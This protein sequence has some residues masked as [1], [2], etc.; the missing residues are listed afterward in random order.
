VKGPK[1]VQVAEGDRS[2]RSVLVQGLS[3]HRVALDMDG[4]GPGTS[5]VERVPVA[6]RFRRA[7]PEESGSAPGLTVGDAVVST[8]DAT[9]PVDHVTLGGPRT[10]VA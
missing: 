5:P 1:G 4:S 6:G 7:A 10:A 8:T 2:L 3:T 9:W